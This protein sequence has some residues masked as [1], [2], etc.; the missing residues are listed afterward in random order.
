MKNSEINKIAKYV[1]KVF[2][3]NNS[4][5]G[6]N[7]S[8]PSD[9]ATQDFVENKIAEEIAKA[10]LGGNGGEILGL[11][12]PTGPTGPTGA[13]GDTGATG[14]TGAKGDTGATG[15][16]GPT[17]EPDYNLVYKKYEID[18]MFADIGAGNTSNT[19]NADTVDGKHIWSGTQAQYDSLTKENNT[20]Y[21]IEDLAIP[22]GP[23]GA[24]GPRGLTGDVGPTGATG[25][26]GLTTKVE[27]DGQTYE[28][29][30]GTIILDNVAS[31]TYV[32]EQIE[33]VNDK[34]DGLRFKRITQEEYDT[35][36]VK[37]PNTLYIIINS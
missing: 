9:L 37:D 35:L 29:I 27:V 1:N 25:K 4:S 21:M 8:Y 3:K 2:E 23:T 11:T 13:K 19:G 17:G 15:P 36:A 6:N 24:T 32:E 33:T 28:H 18:N 12:G 10:Q 5:S 14:P 31:K 30:N 20:I 7:T 34:F 16:T 22:V 26:D